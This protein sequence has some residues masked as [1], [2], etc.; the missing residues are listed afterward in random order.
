MIASGFG[1]YMNERQKLITQTGDEIIDLLDELDPITRA[2]VVKYIVD[3][4]ME[5]ISG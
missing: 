3:Q 5:R 2:E 1:L 4:E